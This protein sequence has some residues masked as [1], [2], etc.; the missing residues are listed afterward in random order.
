VRVLSD[1]GTNV[2]FTNDEADVTSVFSL[3][4][5]V[6]NSKNDIGQESPPTIVDMREEINK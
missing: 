6:T 4:S 3:A 2:Q 5:E 1:L